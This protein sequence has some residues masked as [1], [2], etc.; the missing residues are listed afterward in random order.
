MSRHST[1]ASIKAIRA[2]FEDCAIL[3]RPLTMSII[4]RAVEM[5]PTFVS[6]FSSLLENDSRISS[7]SC[8]I[9]ILQAGNLIWFWFK[10]PKRLLLL[11][12]LI[13]LFSPCPSV[14]TRSYRWRAHVNLCCSLLCFGLLFIGL[15]FSM[16][17][18]EN[19]HHYAKWLSGS[20]VI[21][22]DSIAEIH[23]NSHN[24]MLSSPM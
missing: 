20:F 4:L 6:V 11:F 2:M 5:L 18:I 24:S 9:S 3:E 17:T 22:I 13:K 8:K 21:R 7:C 12:S 16:K 19:Y 10:F 15:T 23:R 1:M 14:W